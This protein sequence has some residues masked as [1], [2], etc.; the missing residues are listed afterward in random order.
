[1][2]PASVSAEALSGRTTALRPPPGYRSLRGRRALRHRR[3]R[4]KTD[5]YLRGK[6]RISYL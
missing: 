3:P 6:R 5:A 4:R 2:S 1:V